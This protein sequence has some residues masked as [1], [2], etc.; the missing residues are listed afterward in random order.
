MA[1][2]GSISNDEQRRVEDVLMQTSRPHRNRGLLILGIETGLRIS[3][4]LSVTVGDVV[5]VSNA[6]KHTL[7]IQKRFCKG[8]QRSRRVRLSPVARDAIYAAVEEARQF[9]ASRREDSLFS[10]SY[11]R[12]SISRRQAYSIIHRSL[13]GVG[14][15]HTGGTH[16]MRKTR[17]QRVVSCA[18]IKFQAGETE[19]VP[20]MAAKGGGFLFG[21]HSRQ[22]LPSG[23]AHRGVEI[24]DVLVENMPEGKKDGVKCLILGRGR[25]FT[26]YS[27]VG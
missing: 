11:R 23:G 5:D 19:V 27:Q 4:L 21:Q 14:I 9:G 1:R 3:E 20:I 13:V 15:T 2:C 25:N 24:F 18:I 6:V 10:P 16:T 7:K 17:A 22:G 26:V 12:G 8:K